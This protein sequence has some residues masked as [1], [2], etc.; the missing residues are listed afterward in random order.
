MRTALKRSRE[1]GLTRVASSALAC[2]MA[3]LVLGA[4]LGAASPSLHKWIHSGAGQPGHECAITLLQQ[5]QLV[6]A[7]GAAIFE[8]AIFSLITL[9][10]LAK[11]VSFPAVTSLLPPGRAP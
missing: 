4:A 7:D 10:L 5:H 9:V 3:F 11:T 8:V 2:L 1:N 6:A